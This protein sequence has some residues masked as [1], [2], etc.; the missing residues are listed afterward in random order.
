[1][2][3]KVSDYEAVH[4]M[5]NWTDLKFRVGPYRRCFVYTHRS[6]PGE[7]I[8]VLGRNSIDIFLGPVSGPEPCLSHFWSFETYLNL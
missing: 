7:P 4:P 5:R 6:M 2:L 3:Q 1:M 8:V